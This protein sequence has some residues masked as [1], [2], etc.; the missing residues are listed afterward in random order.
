MGDARAID[1]EG[2][3]VARLPRGRRLVR[4]WP[5]PV[6]APRM[7]RRKG[8]EEHRLEGPEVRPPLAARPVRDLRYAVVTASALRPCLSVA[9]RLCRE[10]LVQGRW[11]L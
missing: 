10:L 1:G 6:V 7:A 5:G 4:R 2:R 9:S 8:P 11:P 3:A